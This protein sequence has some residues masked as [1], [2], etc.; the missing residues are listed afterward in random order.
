[1]R[2]DHCD[3]TDPN[4]KIVRKTHFFQHVVKVLFDVQNLHLRS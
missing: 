2:N 1:M 4:L 3:L